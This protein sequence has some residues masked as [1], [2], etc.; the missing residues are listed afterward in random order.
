M[1]AIMEVKCCLRKLVLPNVIAAFQHNQ[2]NH[3][4]Q[5]TVSKY[6]VTSCVRCASTHSNPSITKLHCELSHPGEE[7]TL[8]VSHHRF[9]NRSTAIRENQNLL[10]LNLDFAKALSKLRIAFKRQ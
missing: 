4:Q 10:L 6:S 2:S 9:V 3:Q 5:L 8:Y 1:N 7:D